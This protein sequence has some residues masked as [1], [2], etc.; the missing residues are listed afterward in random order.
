MAPLGAIVTYTVLGH[1]TLFTST[2]AVA[3]VVLFSGGTFLYAA[4]MHILPEVLGA[5]CHLSLNQIAAV[6][7][8]GLLPA[9]L[10]FGHEH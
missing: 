4:T 1:I 7:L 5:G 9:M 10:S 6:S 2:S 3:L 8:G